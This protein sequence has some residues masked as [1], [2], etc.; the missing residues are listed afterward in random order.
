MVNGA[1]WQ[2]SLNY[3][4]EIVEIRQLAIKI[5]VLLP[6]KRVAPLA[7]QRKASLVESPG[8]FRFAALHSHERAK[9]VVGFGSGEMHRRGA[10]IEHGE[11]CGFP[12]LAQPFLPFLHLVAR[13][14]DHAPITPYSSRLDILRRNSNCRSPAISTSGVAA[15]V[16]ISSCLTCFQGH[17][18]RGVTTSNRIAEA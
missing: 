8:G 18:M 15:P 12:V 17:S 7:Q 11:Q 5:R 13:V 2:Q 3:E 1:S 6:Q 16:H 9:S 14:H 4:N 10:P